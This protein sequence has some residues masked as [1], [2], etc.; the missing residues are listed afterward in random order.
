V[1]LHV[2][3]AR[4]GRL[5]ERRERVQQRPPAGEERPRRLELRVQAADRPEAAASACR[6]CGV[7]AVRKRASPSPTAADSTS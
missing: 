7:S 4:R 2:E 5:L 1:L 6:Y 3:E